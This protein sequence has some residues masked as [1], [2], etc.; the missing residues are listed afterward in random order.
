ME[1]CQ[2]FQ[3]KQDQPKVNKNL[4]DIWFILCTDSVKFMASEMTGE[5]RKQGVI[6]KLTAIQFKALI[7]N[8]YPHG[9]TP[10]PAQSTL[11]DLGCIDTFSKGLLAQLP[12]IC[13]QIVQQRG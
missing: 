11:K 9:K 12:Y 8:G 4:K 13:V 5:T 6:L 1:S 10:A 7:L 3:C 2:V